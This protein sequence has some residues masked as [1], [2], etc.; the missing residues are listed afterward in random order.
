M[1]VAVLRLTDLMAIGIDSMQREH[2]SDVMEAQSKL[3][4]RC[5]AAHSTT[6]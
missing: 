2:L 6:D 4:V 1:R 5:C 3:R